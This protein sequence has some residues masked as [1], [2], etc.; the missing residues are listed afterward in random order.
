M[1]ALW[2]QIKTYNIVHIHAWRNLFSLLSCLIA[3]PRDGPIIVSPWVTLGPYSLKNRNNKTKWVIHELL[4][5]PILNGAVS[6]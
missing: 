3:L 1:L 4:S 6:M 5:K 2:R